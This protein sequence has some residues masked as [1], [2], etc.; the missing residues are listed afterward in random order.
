MASNVDVVQLGSKQIAVT[1]SKHAL[2]GLKDGQSFAVDLKVKGDTFRMMF[3]RDTDFKE[4]IHQF[5]AHS[6]KLVEQERGFFSKLI[7][8]FRKK[9]NGNQS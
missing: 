9:T 2:A 5:K 6:A 7:N 3:M 4:K 8:R 1:F